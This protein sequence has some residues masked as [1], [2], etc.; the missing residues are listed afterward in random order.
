MPYRILASFLLLVIGAASA[1]APRAAD[2]REEA[3]MDEIETIVRLPAD[4][5]P[6]S[7]YGRSYTYVA[8]GRV[9][10]VYMLPTP[11][12]PADT[13]CEVMTAD[14]KTR[15]CTAKEIA[16]GQAN[17]ARARAAEVPAGQRRW[18]KNERLLPMIADGG[19]MLVTVEY[20]IAAKRILFAQCNGL[21]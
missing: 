7:A 21:A 18:V 13:G 15:P 1:P 10:A 4:A 2:T 3:L 5:Q 14:F 19:C 20:D 12:L 11:P 9:R 17:D 16:E 8:Q 6:L